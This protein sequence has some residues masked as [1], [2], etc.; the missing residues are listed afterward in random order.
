M[1]RRRRVFISAGEASGDRLGAGL[2]RALLERDPNL[3]LVGM[4]GPLMRAAGVELIQD[5]AEVAVMGFFEVLGRLPVIHRA[6]GRLERSLK[7]NPPD[8]L[9]PID[10]PDFNLNL[11]GRANRNG[12]P[13]VYFVSPQVWAWRRGRVRK[14]RDVVRRMLVLFPFEAAFYES[15]GVPVTFVGHPIVD[16]LDDRAPR[17]GLIESAGLLPGRPTVALMPGSRRSEVKQLLGPMAGAAARIR[18]R[19]RDVQFL[20]PLAPGLAGDP[21]LEELR[22]HDL[23]QTKVHR[24]DFPQILG[25]CDAGVVASGTASLEAALEGLPVAVVYRVNPLTYGLGKALVR[26]ENVALPN[27]VAGRRIVPELIQGECTAPRIAQEVLGY[28]DSPERAQEVRSAL[29]ELRGR[30]GGPGALGRAAEAILG[31][32]GGLA[33]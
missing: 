15:E 8:I 10:F 16:G 28:L 13:V 18:E 22:R 19:H 27:L 32:L 2:A 5:A 23:P 14:M 21:I 6:M 3:D 4:G 29:L 20:I 26:L 17:D 12:I 25:A 24:G 7:D 33:G 31:E 9:V 11:A 1:S 30:L